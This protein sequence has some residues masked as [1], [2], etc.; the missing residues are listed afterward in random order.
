MVEDKV[1]KE[2]VA[3]GATAKE[4]ADAVDGAVANRVP[5]TE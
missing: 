4:A 3:H 5:T 2:A 1:Q